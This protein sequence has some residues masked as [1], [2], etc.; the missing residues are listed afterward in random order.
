MTAPRISGPPKTHH[1]FSDLPIDT[2]EARAVPA[3]TRQPPQRTAGTERKQLGDMA[4][5]PPDPPGPAAARRNARSGARPTA[6][7]GTLN[8]PS[9]RSRRKRSGR[10]WAASRAAAARKPPQQGGTAGPGKRRQAPSTPSTAGSASNRFIGH[11]P[12]DRFTQ[13]GLAVAPASHYAASTTAIAG[14]LTGANDNS[15]ANDCN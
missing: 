8:R 11:I 5:N 3:L 6:D 14:S 2:D 12:P 1:A 10:N 15:P 7:A 9:S 13:F 4:P